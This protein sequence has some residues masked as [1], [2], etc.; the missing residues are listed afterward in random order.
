MLCSEKNSQSEKGGSFL[1]QHPPQ[2]PE[3]LLFLV[4]YSGNGQW[5]K[6]WDS[7]IVPFL[8]TCNV[9][10]NYFQKLIIYERFCKKGLSTIQVMTWG[11]QEMLSSIYPQYLACSIYPINMFIDVDYDN[12]SIRSWMYS[13]L[14]Y[15]QGRDVLNEAWVRE[16][17]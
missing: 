12:I 16:V 3:M 6:D 10:E 1:S 14:G 2:E 17:K 9:E 4:F 5:C 13:P 15:S 7:R 8:G 11:N